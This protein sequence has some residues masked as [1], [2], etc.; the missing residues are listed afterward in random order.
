M[1]WL[2]LNARVAE[3]TAVERARKGGV[4]IAFG[5]NAVDIQ[6]SWEACSKVFYAS[7]LDKCSRMSSDLQ[8]NS[9]ALYPPRPRKI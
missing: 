9:L 8:S 3:T 5:M 7:H 6:V 1:K 2:L 4:D